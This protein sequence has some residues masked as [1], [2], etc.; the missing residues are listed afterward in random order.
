M[1]GSIVASSRI[2]TP[3]KALRKRYKFSVRK[4][5]SLGRRN[6]TEFQSFNSSFKNERAGLSFADF[7]D[8]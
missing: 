5:K 1:R 4:I 8:G 3:T 6:V 2:N 7:V